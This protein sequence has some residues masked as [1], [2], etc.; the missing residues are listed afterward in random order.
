MSSAEPTIAQDRSTIA[1]RKG[2]VLQVVSGAEREVLGLLAIAAADADYELIDFARRAA[3]KL[4]Q[5]SHELST[6]RAGDSPT[7]T[8]AQVARRSESGTE[9]KSVTLR[10]QKKRGAYPSFSVRD[11]FLVKTGWS[12]RDGT[13]YDQRVA[14]KTFDAVVAVLD[15]L[16]GLDGHTVPVA[17]N[18]ILEMVLA[19]D[20]SNVPPP[21][22]Q[23]YAVIAFLRGEEAIRRVTRGEYVVQ[24]DA[25]AR[26]TAAWDR[27]A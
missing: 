25:A 1:G 7:A 15:T 24:M 6:G 17:T 12:K 9:E 20:R 2:Q 8:H 21:S 5:V 4:H 13:T 3:Q 11:N 14:K 10:R 18:D 27:L 19:T 26:A 16:G 22:Y 23:I